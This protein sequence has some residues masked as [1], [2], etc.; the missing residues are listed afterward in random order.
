MSNSVDRGRCEHCSR[1]FAYALL[2]NGFNDSAYAY[3]DSCCNVA[4]LSAW[5]K[6][7]PS[8]AAFRAHGPISEATES[9]LQPCPRGGSFKANASPRCPHCNGL[10]SAES[11]RTWIEQNAAGIAKGWRWQGSWSGLYCIVIEHQAVKDNWRDAAA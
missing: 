10:L 2:H 3:C 7:I 11:A 5:H 6:G 9:W 8:G 4:V 1:D